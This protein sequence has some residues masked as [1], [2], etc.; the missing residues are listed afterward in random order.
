MVCELKKSLYGLKQSPCAWFERFSK[1]IK[2]HEYSQ[3]NIGRTKH[4]E[5][6]RHFIIEKLEKGVI[7]IKYIPINQ[8]VVDILIKGLTGLA[9]N[10]LT[11]KLGLIDIYGLA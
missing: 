5:V 7:S 11:S 1:V 9:F 8:Q 3:G 4:V 6:D 2:S 10:F